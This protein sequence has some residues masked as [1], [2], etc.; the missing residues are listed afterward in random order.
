[1]H[2]SCSCIRCFF[3][4]TITTLAYRRV[5]M[6]DNTVRREEK[7]IGGGWQA[8]RAR[9][10][11]G[12]GQAG[13]PFPQIH[14]ACRQRQAR[15]RRGRTANFPRASSRERSAQPLRLRA[16]DRQRFMY[17]RKWVRPFAGERTK[18]ELAMYLSSPSLRAPRGPRTRPRQ[19]D[20]VPLR[21]KETPAR[22][23]PR[24]PQHRD[25]IIGQRRYSNPFGTY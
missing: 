18:H 8:I 2:Q 1:M 14:R 12:Y 5:M 11:P 23:P 15:N 16:Q 24:L 7:C 10:Q 4:S 9:P 13:P 17:P 19:P 6:F 22:A 3:W 21:R 25:R 20:G